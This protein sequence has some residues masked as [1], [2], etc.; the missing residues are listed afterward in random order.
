MTWST[1][2]DV[3]NCDNQWPG[4][5]TFNCHIIQFYFSFVL[6]CYVMLF[7]Y[8]YI[9]WQ[10]EKLESSDEGEEEAHPYTE[11][12]DI[13]GIDAEANTQEM[14]KKWKENEDKEVQDE[15]TDL[16]KKKVKGHRLKFYISF[17]ECL[18]HFL[19]WQTMIFDLWPV[20]CVF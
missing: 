2:K 5:C 19:Y 15:K 12:L 7:I 4:K 11:L 10:I 3:E 18:G 20:T 9:F 6:F 16:N 17:E 13:F 8:L 1:Q 14:I